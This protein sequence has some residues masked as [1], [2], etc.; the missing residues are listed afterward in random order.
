MYLT[1]INFT[2]SPD[3]EEESRDAACT[4]NVTQECEAPRTATH[5]KTRVS[6]VKFLAIGRGVA[7]KRSVLKLTSCVAEPTR[8][9][10][11]S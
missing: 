9:T 3:A 1:C 5:R 11:F 10:H 4:I 7:A 8:T 2:T 6:I